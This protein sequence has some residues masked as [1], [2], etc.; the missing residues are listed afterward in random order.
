MLFER[1]RQAWIK[2]KEN[3][4]IVTIA[5]RYDFLNKSLQERNKV[6]KEVQKLFSNL[7]KNFNKEKYS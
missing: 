5:K 6:N 3:R 4:E 1:K 7:D 2:D